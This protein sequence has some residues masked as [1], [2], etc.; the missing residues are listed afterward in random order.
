MQSRSNTVRRVTL[1]VLAIVKDFKY[2][3]NFHDRRMLTVPSTWLTIC[4]PAT[5]RA[6]CKGAADVAMRG[7]HW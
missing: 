5:D 1:E 3:G 6:T 7:C 4:G 2:M